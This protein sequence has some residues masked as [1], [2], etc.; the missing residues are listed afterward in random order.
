MEILQAHSLYPIYFTQVGYPT[1]SI[2]PYINYN[3]DD[4]SGFDFSP[5]LNKKVSEVD[6]HSV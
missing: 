5:Y 4:R 1:S 2:I 3:I 6:L